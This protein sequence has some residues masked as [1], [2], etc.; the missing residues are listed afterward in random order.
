MAG[1]KCVFS[2]KR[3]ISTANK[4]TQE[5]SYYISSQD[6]DVSAKELLFL[7]REHWKIESMHCFYKSN[8]YR[9]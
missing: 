9:I 3:I 1:L 5:T 2:V 6:Q 4:T 8:I 7:S